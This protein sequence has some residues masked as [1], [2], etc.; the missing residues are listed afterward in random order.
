MLA[1]MHRGGMAIGSHTK[2]HALLTNE[3][4]Q[5]V[6]D[7]TAGS[8][9]ELERKLRL[10]VDHFAYP[11][12]RFDSSV[13]NAVAAAG[14]RFGYTTCRHRDRTR[15]LLTIPRRVFWQNSCLD[16]FGRF[17]S[18]MMDCQVKGTFDFGARCKQEH[19]G[20]AVI[21]RSTDQ[22]STDREPASLLEDGF[23]K[24][25]SSDLED[26]GASAVGQGDYAGSGLAAYRGRQRDHRGARMSVRG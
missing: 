20:A 7:E 10:R 21:Q 6:L 5:K 22:R 15:P 24:Q 13:V 18:P 26:S 2:T 25:N 4:P 11:C 12:G 23:V 17:S 9:R 14:Y 16:A 19:R 1:E 3:S 8:R